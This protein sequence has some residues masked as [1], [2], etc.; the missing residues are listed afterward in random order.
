[1]NKLPLKVKKKIRKLSDALLFSQFSDLNGSR[2]K[3]STTNIKTGKNLPFLNSATNVLD[4][5][6]LPCHK[7][8][9]SRECFN[10]FSRESTT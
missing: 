5:R 1:M 6:I 3:D 10:V 8:V 7:N 2:K 4:S 9:Y